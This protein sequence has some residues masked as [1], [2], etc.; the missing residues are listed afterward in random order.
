[1]CQKRRNSPE[2]R[3]AGGGT[4]E[5]SP[6]VVLKNAPRC[7]NFDSSQTPTSTAASAAGRRR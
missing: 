7:R 2:K 4:V 1:M 3:P 5:K 6:P